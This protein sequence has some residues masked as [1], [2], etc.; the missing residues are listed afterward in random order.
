M[1]SAARGLF[2]FGIY[3]IVAGAGLLI[4]PTLV[5]STLGFPPTQDGWVRV[6]GALAVIIGWYRTVAARHELLPYM[7]VSVSGR[8]AF[9]GLLGALVAT[10]SMP[11]SLLILAGVDVAGALWTGVALRSHAHASTAAV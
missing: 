7:R 1:T 4:L 2:V 3:A 9:A 8:I 11:P 10:S 6:V 5:L